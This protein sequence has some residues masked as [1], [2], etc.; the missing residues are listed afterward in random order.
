MKKRTE[1]LSQG[2]GAATAKRLSAKG[3]TTVKQIRACTKV[4]RKNERDDREKLKRRRDNTD[5]CKQ[6]QRTEQKG[7]REEQ[8]RE[9]KISLLLFER[10]F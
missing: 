1:S 2:V 9:E 7:H 5:K 3:I 8:R 6:K 4:K 10:N